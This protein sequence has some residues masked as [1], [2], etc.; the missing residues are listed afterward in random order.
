M[1]QVGISE[2]GDE[3]HKNVDV[4]SS[5]TRALGDFDALDEL[6]TSDLCS[7]LGTYRQTADVVLARKV[8]PFARTGYGRQ[9]IA[10]ALGAPKASVSRALA[11]I[12]DSLRFC[13]E[14]G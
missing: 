11:L 1:E 3:P 9:E 2:F 13:L 7:L 4:S 14:D 10:E 5:N 12:R 6:I 8:L